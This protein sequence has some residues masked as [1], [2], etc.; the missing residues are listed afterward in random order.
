MST[1]DLAAANKPFWA[2]YDR[3]WRR[4]MT[5]LNRAEGSSYPAL[6]HLRANVQ[7]KRHFINDLFTL[8]E[9]LTMSDH[10]NVIQTS[11]T[12]PLQP[13]IAIPVSAPL[14]LLQPLLL[15]LLPLPCQLLAPLQGV[16]RKQIGL[17]V[18]DE[19]R[20]PGLGTVP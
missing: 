20:A 18:L 9:G 4:T 2:V 17:L 10:A 19:P 12:L 14:L 5:I 7:Y 15:K 13:A 3:D 1:N 11:A 6:D 16:S 8:I